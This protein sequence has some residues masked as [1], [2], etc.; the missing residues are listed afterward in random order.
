MA[1]FQCGCGSLLKAVHYST[2][3]SEDGEYR[4]A[5]Y[6]IGGAMAAGEWRALEEKMGWLRG[7]SSGY[8]CPSCANSLKLEPAEEAK[9]QDERIPGVSANEF[10]AETIGEDIK[11]LGE[12]ERADLFFHTIPSKSASFKSTEEMIHPKLQEALERMGVSSLYSHQ[13]ETFDAVQR[14]KD[15]VLVTQTASG[16]TISFNLP[17]LQGMMEDPSAK[18]IYLF[19]TKALADDQVE[20]L[21]RFSE[22][23]SGLEETDEWFEREIVLAG[24]RILFGRVDGDTPL[25]S[26]KR[27]L[28]NGRIL[29]TNPDMI[30]HTILK[31][32]SGRNRVQTIGL[33]RNLKF[34]V[35]DEMHLYRGAFGTHVSMVL[36][37]IQKLCTELGNSELQLI[38]CSATIDKPVQLAKDLTGRQAFTLLDRDGS[39]RQ[40]R[41]IIFWNP[42]LT[43]DTGERKAPISDGLSLAEHVLVQDRKVIRT[44]M[45]QGSRLQGKVSARNMKD[46]LRK[47]LKLSREKV[48]GVKLAAFYNGMLSVEERKQIMESLKKS[49]THVVLSTNALEVGIDIGDLSLALIMGY[50]GSKAAFSQQIGRVG[51]KGEGI[52][53]MIFEDEPLQQFYMQ[54]PEAFFEKPPEVVRIN[55]HNSNFLSKHLSYLEQELGRTLLLDEIQEFIPDLSKAALLL[56]EVEQNR[57][58]SQGERCSLRSDTSVTYKVIQTKNRTVLMES[59]DEWTAMRDFHTGAIYWDA[60]ERFYRVDSYNRHKHEILLVPL[61]GM[62]EYY[63]QSVFKDSLKIIEEQ[64]LNQQYGWTGTLEI[65]RAVFGYT[66][67]HFHNR[68]QE[69]ETLENPIS[70]TFLADGVWFPIPN[71]TLKELEII[72]DMNDYK[73]DGSIRAAEH[74]L[75]S[76][77]PDTVICDS[78]DISGYSGF[79]LS[80][81]GGQSV[82]VFYGNQSGGLGIPQAVAEHM[83]RI[84]VNAIKLL[85]SCPCKGGCPACIQQP[86]KDNENL[87]KQGAVM[88]LNAMLEKILE[89]KNGALQWH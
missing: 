53:I 48:S 51:R 37:R 4:L 55:P 6:Q 2:L 34:L 56:K 76:V 84:A 86:G 12:K 78:R 1:F 23:S 42:G 87:F 21:G 5:E 36:K 35:I 40:A 57:E 74:V 89:E 82:I 8:Y 27:L 24:H 50:P 71:E 11:R 61:T 73:L 26:R 46:V 68:M 33:L 47:K 58:T 72:E 60:N 44:I 54:N 16:K 83:E 22:T 49:E 62:S 45:F 75:L 39:A 70:A 59:L 31:N 19:P 52:A 20:Q 85:N 67:I 14:K 18:A 64:Q 77:I 15:V 69:K 13:A 28:D 41:S 29:F 30:H 32:L 80:A 79:S 43:L 9:L 25:G 38:L 10:Q 66:K 81:F 17:V 88:V 63:T 3:V 65:K 7:K